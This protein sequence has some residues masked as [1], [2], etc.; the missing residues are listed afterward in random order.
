MAIALSLAACGATERAPSTSVSAASSEATAQPLQAC[1]P[2]AHASQP[3]Q[4]L[5]DCPWGYSCTELGFA[6]CV[7]TDCNQ[8]KLCPDGYT[9]ESEDGPGR[10]HGVGRCVDA[11]DRYLELEPCE[12]VVEAP[13]QASPADESPCSTPDASWGEWPQGGVVVR[14]PD[15]TSSRTI[16]LSLAEGEEIR[17][18]LERFMRT[19]AALEHRYPEELARQIPQWQVGAPNIGVGNTPRVGQFFVQLGDQDELVLSHTPMLRDNFR[20]QLSARVVR[21]QQRWRTVSLSGQAI[22]R[23]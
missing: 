22:R 23:R 10:H 19:P 9:C 3:C 21:F 5:A 20:Y 6:S 4:G 1:L 15:T 11:Q 13:P 7:E 8:H 12:E 14:S 18:A 17:C 2:L 16:R